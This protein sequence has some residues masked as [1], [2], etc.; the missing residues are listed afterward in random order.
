MYQSASLRACIALATVLLCTSSNL[1]CGSLD[2]K[3]NEDHRTV[4]P[5]SY[6]QK[7][8][9]GLH[10][11]KHNVNTHHY[12]EYISMNW[13]GLICGCCF[14]VVLQKFPKGLNDVLHIQ[15]AVTNNIQFILQLTD[16]Y[17]ISCML[18]FANINSRQHKLYQKLFCTYT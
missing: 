14:N 8:Y 15:L 16:T 13:G 6:V 4:P 17:F 7:K 10:H 18:N 9:R 3:V 5:L 2:L 11:S 1:Q 12:F